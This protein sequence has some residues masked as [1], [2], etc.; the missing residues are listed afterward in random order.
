MNAAT[1]IGPRSWIRSAIRTP[2]SAVTSLL[3]DR[4]ERLA[5]AAPDTKLREMLRL[6]LLQLAL[7][8]G[9]VRHALAVHRQDD[10]ARP[11]EAGGRTVLIDVRHDS[12]RLPGRQPQPPRHLR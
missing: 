7:R 5:V 8:I 4:H 6:N 2:Q 9:R 3:A 1:V 11:Q 12:A 10:V